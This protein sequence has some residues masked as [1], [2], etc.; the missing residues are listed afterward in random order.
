MKKVLSP[1]EQLNVMIVLAVNG[2][3]GQYDKAGMPYILHCLKVMHYL[4]SEDYELL[5]IAVGHDLIEDT[6]TTYAQLRELGIS[7]RVIDGIMAL[8]KLPGETEEE[9]L[10]K[11]LNNY[12]ACRVKLADLRHNSDFRRLKGLTQKDFDR[13]IKYQKWYAAISARVEEYKAMPALI[14]SLKQPLA[15]S[16]TD[17]QRQAAMLFVSRYAPCPH[18]NVTSDLGDGQT[19]VKCE[20][21]GRTLERSRIVA[22]KEAARKFEEALEVLCK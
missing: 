5:A 7:E 14:Q 1:I 15:P 12:D 13:M 16:V 6:K 18:D 9:Q 22:A 10:N 8:T 4:K 19:W 17:E 3:N 2:H 20:D 21:C 11:V